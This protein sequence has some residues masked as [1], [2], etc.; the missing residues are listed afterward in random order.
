MSDY[1]E[2]EPGLVIDSEGEIIESASIDDAMKFLAARRHEAKQ[3]LKAYEHYIDDLDRVLLRY[4]K[5]RKLAYGD[6]VISVRGGTYRKTD[7]Q[8]FADMLSAMAVEFD[9]LM[10]LVAAA[11]GF[12]RDDVPEILRDA[13]DDCT[14][15]LE[16][17][18][19]I[20]SDVARKPAPVMAAPSGKMLAGLEASV[21]AL[22]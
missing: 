7:A 4:Q 22:S 8:K 15:T 9:D 2:V 1:I 21:E 13:Y 17:R 19:W 12:K 14:A 20:E 3:Q 16:K 10:G 18:P 11:T 5:D 6:V